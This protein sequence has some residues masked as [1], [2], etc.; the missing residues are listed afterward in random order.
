MY[1]IQV[2]ASFSA[3]HQIRLPDGQIEPLHGHDWK[4]AVVLASERLDEL[5]MVAD[6][7]DVQSHLEQTVANLNHTNLN[8]HAWFADEPT[9]AE[10]VADVLFRQLVT[11]KPWGECLRSVAVEESPGCIARFVRSH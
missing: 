7:E 8:M 2:H 9:S 5:G 4:V 10:R 1:E 6:F 11:V 3:T